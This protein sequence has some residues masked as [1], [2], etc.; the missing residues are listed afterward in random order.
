MKTACNYQN[1]NRGRLVVD[2]IPRSI[3]SD[4]SSKANEPGTS[5]FPRRQPIESE[6]I[7]SG[8]FSDDEKRLPFAPRHRRPINPVSHS[9]KS[10][11]SPNGS[12][13]PEILK[14]SQAKLPRRQRRK[15]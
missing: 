2:F 4:A 3:G 10:C 11:A 9:I 1:F 8:A 12:R 15:Y 7:R 13:R 5:L 14:R 6:R